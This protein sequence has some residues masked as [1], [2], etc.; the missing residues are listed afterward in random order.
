LASQPQQLQKVQS[1]G[2]VVRLNR[3]RATHAADGEPVV[4]GVGRRRGH[5]F[6]RARPMAP[7]SDCSEHRHGICSCRGSG[8]LERLRNDS[9]RHGHGAGRAV[10]SPE[11][12]LTAS[13]LHASEPAYAA[14]TSH[15]AASMK[16]EAGLLIAPSVLGIAGTPRVTTATARGAVGYV[17]RRFM[18]RPPVGP[19]E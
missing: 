8:A 2:S 19:S 17:N 11:L 1:L 15:R 4:I 9:Q 14:R 10:A 6:H 3:E 12:C 7:A 5:S 16:R 18:R 13:R